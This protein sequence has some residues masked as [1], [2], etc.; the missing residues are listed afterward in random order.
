MDNF[1]DLLPGESGSVE[2][3]A[4]DRSVHVLVVPLPWVHLIALLIKD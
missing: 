4:H 3:I 2:V 1:V